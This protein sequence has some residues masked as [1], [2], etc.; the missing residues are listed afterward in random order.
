[1]SFISRKSHN[2]RCCG[3]DCDNTF[4]FFHLIK[5]VFGS[6]GRIILSVR[7]HQRLAR[8]DVKRHVPVP[9][10]LVL[11]GRLISFAF[12]CHDV[13]Y[14]RLTGIFNRFECIDKRTDIITVA[15]IHIIKSH[16]FKKITFSLTVGFP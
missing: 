13:D 4:I 16:R 11:L 7:I 14:N 2:R 3:R 12:E 1:M 9:C 6:H 15:Y 5:Q 8:L 10:L